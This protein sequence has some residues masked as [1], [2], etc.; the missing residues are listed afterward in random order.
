MEDVARAGELARA[1]AER[2]A[3]LISMLADLDDATLLQRGALPDW[4]R[5]T[6]VC[7]LRY[8]AHALRRMTVDALAGRETSY[9]PDTRARQRES[10]LRPAPGERPTEILDDWQSTAADLDNIWSS[11]QHTQ[12][13]IEVT[14]PADNR[15]LGTIPL[16]RL[17]LAR[18][19]EVDVHGTDLDIDFPDWSRVLVEVGLP[20]RLAWL[21]SRR[22]NHRQFDESISGTWLLQATDGP[23]WLI[24]VEDDHVVSRPAASNDHSD[25]TIQGSSRDL[26]ALLL[27]RPAHEAFYFSGDVE[28]AR[29]FKRAF[30]GP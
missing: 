15:D 30:P 26:L 18:L 23:S 27:G 24:A 21:A 17:A 12:W 10:T 20:T 1:A 5:L 16:G 8:G 25:A 14:E 11:L 7:H 19:T 3:H 2:T 22:T 4:S 9:Y 6:I 13:G 29:S 28:L